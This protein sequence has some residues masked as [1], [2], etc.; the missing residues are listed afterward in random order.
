MELKDLTFDIKAKPS[1]LAVIQMA[2]KEFIPKD[3]KGQSDYHWHARQ[4]LE[5]NS[6]LFDLAWEHW[7]DAP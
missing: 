7:F 6:K 1:E 4:L 3:P 5:N 2:L